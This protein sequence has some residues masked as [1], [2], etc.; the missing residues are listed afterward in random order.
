MPQVIADP[1]PF[2][3]QGDLS[4]ANTAILVIDMQVDFCG[5]G[6]YMDQ[7]GCD[8]SL[9]RAPIAPIQSVLAVARSH[10]FPIIYTREGHRPDLADLSDVKR[11]RS[12]RAGAEIGSQGK[13]GR[14]LIRGEPGWDII[15]ELTPHPD[16]PVIDKPGQSAFYSTDLDLLLR[17]RGI[18]NLIFCGVTTS[19][20]VHSSLREARDRGYDNLLLEDCCAE[21]V[22]ELHTA[23]IAM[24]KLEGGIFGT[25]ARSEN[26]IEAI[27]QL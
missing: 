7:Q 6:G 1:Y 14:L 19:I 12:Q 3:Y 5:L 2:P 9:T 20:C 4:P 21:S 16:D 10:H 24:M 17:N 22:P 25:V 23:A 27:E 8:I 18:T 13:M 26:L 11:W 15:P